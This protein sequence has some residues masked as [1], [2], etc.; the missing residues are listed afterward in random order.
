MEDG[1]RIG[2]E[3]RIA[4][5]PLV[6]ILP[7]RRLAPNVARSKK[8]ARVVASIAEVGMIEP[9]A[10]SK[11]NA[12]GKHLLLDGHLRYYALCDRGDQTARCLIEDDDESFTY[13]KRVARLATVQEHYMI[14]RALG[15]GASVEKIARAF[16]MEVKSLTKRR[17]MLDGIAPDV[18]E[19][20]KDRTISKAIFDALRKMKPLRQYEAADLMLQA[21]N[22]TTSYAKALLAGTKKSDLVSP[23]KPKRLSGLSPDQMAR[24]ERELEVVSRD[25]KAVERTFGDDI[26]HL[27]LASRYVGR[28]MANPNVVSYME[29][30][31]PDMLAELRT[32][33]A[34]TSLEQSS[35]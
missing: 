19:L 13:N 27:V 24:M 14:E 15:K 11:A 26:L 2:F 1:I 34:A 32:I 16:G 21:G 8:Y 5:L 29:R 12:A 10:V 25:F 33:V 30:K 31:H 7:L 4:E 23:E 17:S 28:L 22:L 18:I 35:A 3:N 9:L 6:D 20:L